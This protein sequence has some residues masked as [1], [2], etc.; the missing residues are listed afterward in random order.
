MECIL[1]QIHFN[2]MIVSNETTFF[3]I[4][5]GY[6]AFQFSN[7]LHYAQFLGIFTDAKHFYL[8]T[9]MANVKKIYSKVERKV[10]TSIKSA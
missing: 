6:T 7:L 3:A 1:S 8:V 9:L 2:L 4:L 10:E 5:E